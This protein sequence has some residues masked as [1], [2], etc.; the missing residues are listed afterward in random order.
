VKRPLITFL[1]CTVRPEHNC[2]AEHPEWG[3]LT[4]LIQMLEKQTFRDFELVIVDGLLRDDIPVD[5]QRSELTSSK[6][7]ITHV[8]PLTYSP[9]V[10]QRRVAISAYRNTG[11][12]HAR[13][14]LIVNLDDTATLPPVLAAVFAA[15]WSMNQTA[16]ALC[17]PHLGDQRS[18]GPVDRPGMVF[19]FGSYPLELA[20]RLNGYNEA[21]DGGQGLEDMEW[22]TRLYRAGLQ[23]AL[24]AVP[25]FNIEPQGPHS[26]DAI[27][28][29]NPIVKCCNVAWHVCQVAS[30]VDVAGTAA[31]W[32]L[33]PRL[34][35]D[36]RQLRASLA[37]PCFLLNDD[38]SCQHHG[39]RTKCAY[40]QWAKRETVVLETLLTNA[41]PVIDLMGMRAEMGSDDRG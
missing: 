40:L 41:H 34:S 4:R 35:S 8:A 11:L 23:Q 31:F 15:A 6:F 10:R 9:W 32:G 12:V 30:R 39:G 16:L 5:N 20:L 1:Y 27:D 13:G 22:S 18:P 25:G 33:P 17:W 3:N 7:A 26:P 36:Q 29:A 24:V 37:S 2:Y 21:F 14:E 38:D 19:G 28:S